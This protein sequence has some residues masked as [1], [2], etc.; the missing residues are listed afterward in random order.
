MHYFPGVP[1]DAWGDMPYELV[2]GCISFVDAR[3]GNGDEEG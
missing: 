3:I 1:W 2:M